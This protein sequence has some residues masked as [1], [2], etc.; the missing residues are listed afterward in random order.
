MHT[1]ECMRGRWC[2]REEPKGRGVRGGSVVVVVRHY[3]SG[4]VI[5]EDVQ[6]VKQIVMIENAGA[7]V[8]LEIPAKC[9]DVQMVEDRR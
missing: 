3:V 8:L 5:L 7:C 9:P 4:D 1:G 2:S 6:P